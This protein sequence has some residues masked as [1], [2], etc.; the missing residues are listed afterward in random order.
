MSNL[1]SLECRLVSPIRKP[2]YYEWK[3]WDNYTAVYGDIDHRPDNDK[4]LLH[5]VIAYESPNDTHE[6]IVLELL[7]A[8]RDSESGMML[9]NQFYDY[10]ELAPIL[11]KV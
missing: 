2:S 3:L 10:S 8:V 11:S 5:Y 9:N 1:F 4:D 7:K 6:E